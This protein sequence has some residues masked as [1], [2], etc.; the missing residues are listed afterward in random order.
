MLDRAYCVQVIELGLRASGFKQACQDAF[1]A[2]V[3]EGVHDARGSNGIVHIS[4]SITIIALP[5]CCGALFMGDAKD[6]SLYF[7]LSEGAEVRGTTSGGT[8]DVLGYG[9]CVVGKLVT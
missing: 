6:V 4:K 8:V 7:F 3:N 1:I 2:V 9:H 5:Q